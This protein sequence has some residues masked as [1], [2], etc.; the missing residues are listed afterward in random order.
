MQ[1]S[2]LYQDQKESAD[3]ANALLDFCSR[4]C[5]GPGLDEILNRTVELFGAHP[6]FPA[7]ERLA[8]ESDTGDLVAEAQYGY[9]GSELVAD[10]T[11]SRFPSRPSRGTRFRTRAFLRLS[12]QILIEQ[13][14]LPGDFCG[15]VAVA[16]LKLDRGIGAIV[17]GAPALGDYEF[18]ERKMKLLAGIGHQARLAI[19]NAVAS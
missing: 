15:H 1:K 6:R 9:E 2:I 7:D 19:N 3:I 17:V 14:G 18:S 10:L 8:S 16:P 12:D 4:A 5:G 13:L 11:A